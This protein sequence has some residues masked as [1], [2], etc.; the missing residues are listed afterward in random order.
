MCTDMAVPVP[1][2]A[3]NVPHSEEN[4]GRKN[5]RHPLPDMHNMAQGLASDTLERSGPHF[6]S[7]EDEEE[8]IKR[9][10]NANAEDPLNLEMN[11]EEPDELLYIWPPPRKVSESTKKMV[12]IDPDFSVKVSSSSAVLARGIK[13]YE[14][15]IKNKT[16]SPL[17]SMGC[18][19]PGIRHVV[20]ELESDGENLDL[21]T[22]YQ[23][24]LMISVNM[25]VTI[26]AASPYG[27]L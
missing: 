2:P 18:A 19:K 6:R 15:I 7:V 25:G 24:S 27:A 23:Y 11:R 10:L 12:A 22:S 1:F 4:E 16:S 14:A 21:D 3:W 17:T 13:R 5:R 8:D 9:T 20:I 26:H